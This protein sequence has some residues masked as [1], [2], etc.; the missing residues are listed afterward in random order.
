MNLHLVVDTYHLA[1]QV[2]WADATYLTLLRAALLHKHRRR[3][4]KRCLVC[5]LNRP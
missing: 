2:R 4:M 5:I 3:S 1:K